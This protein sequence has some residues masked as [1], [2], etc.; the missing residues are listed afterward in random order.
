MIILMPFDLC[1]FHNFS[2]HDQINL[3]VFLR[4]T[5]INFEFQHLQYT[6]CFQFHIPSCLSHSIS[7][8]EHICVTCVTFEG[9]FA[10]SQKTPVTFVPSICL[11]V[12]PSA[13]VS[14]SPTETISVTGDMGDFQ[15]VCRDNPNSIKIW[16]KYQ[17][18]YVKT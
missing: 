1:L 8:N 5:C 2:L 7:G 3:L 10:K 13:Y 11:S 6:F 15:K 17:E 14:A 9:V 16:G 18:L 4:L 12:F